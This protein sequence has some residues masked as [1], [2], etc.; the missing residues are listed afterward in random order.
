M[1]TDLPYS[2]RPLNI[3]EPKSLI[4]QGATDCHFH[5]FGPRKQY[6]IVSTS[7][8]DPQ[9]STVD[10]YL[11]MASTLGLDRRVIVQASIYGTDNS[12]LLDAIKD[13][14]PAQTRGIAVVDSSVSDDTLRT[15]DAAGVRGIRFN[16]VS[17]GISLDD[18]PQLARRIAPFGW[19]VQLWIKGEGLAAIEPVLAALPVP[20]CIDHLGQIDPRKGLDHAEFRC[21][22][23]CLRGGRTWIKLLVYRTSMQAYPHDDVEDQVRAIVAT[24]PDRC[25]WGTDWPHPLL[26]HQAMPDAG[27][28][29]DLLHSWMNDEEQFRRVLV[30]NPAELYGFH[31]DVIR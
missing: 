12:C 13:M 29:L 20:V 17:G 21:L 30:D 14:G 27:Q 11:A 9:E 1:P 31:S 19:H 15:L 8:Y 10:N 2:P 4:P 3:S 18:L 5:I 6:P 23:R 26:E 22:E 7:L 25:V 28:L 16:A 24:A